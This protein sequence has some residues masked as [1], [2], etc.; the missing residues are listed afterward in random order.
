M[1]FT[2]FAQAH[3]L[4]INSLYPSQKIKRCPTVDKPRSTNGAYFYDGERGWVFRW[5]AEATVQWWHDPNAKPWTEEQ[6]AELRKRQAQDMKAKREEQARVAKLAGQILA[7]CELQRHGYLTAKGFPEAL[8][9]VLDSVLHIP[10]RNAKTNQIQGL[11][12]IEMV[13]GKY[14]KKFMYGQSSK[15]AVLFLGDKANPQRIFCE[16]YSTGLSIQA[17]LKQ[18]RL[19]YTV[20]VCFSAKNMRS[21]AALLGGNGYVF[22]DNDKEDSMGRRAGQMAAE[23]IG[24]PW[25]MADTEGFDAN[26]MHQQD[27]LFALCRKVQELIGK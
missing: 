23:E 24:L 8:G 9:L 1:S 4:V 20:V 13:D 2:N 7:D 12:R 26:D 6:M 19:Q 17:A 21:V 11:Q 25:V 5:D 14:S 3:G 18:M 10:M 16:G 22:A 27:G 15:D